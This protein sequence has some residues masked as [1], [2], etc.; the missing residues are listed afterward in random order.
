M[1]LFSQMLRGGNM[2]ETSGQYDIEKYGAASGLAIK[3]RTFK[4]NIQDQIAYHKRKVAELE[5]VRDSLSPEIEKFVEAMQ[6][7]G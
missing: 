1:S 6:K 7:L 4:E 2:P 5:E 3:P